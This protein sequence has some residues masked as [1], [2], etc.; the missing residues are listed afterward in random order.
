MTSCF[1]WFMLEFIGTTPTHRKIIKI[2]WGYRS[3]QFGTEIQ[4][5]RYCLCV[6]RQGTNEWS[7]PDEG[8][9]G[10]RGVGLPFR[11][12]TTDHLKKIYYLITMKASC[13][14]MRNVC[15]NCV[16]V[17]ISRENN[18]FRVSC[19]TSMYIRLLQAYF[20]LKTITIVCKCWFIFVIILTFW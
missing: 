14:R 20:F 15:L 9:E 18:N 10:L 17:R 1:Q 12:D 4:H 19:Q 5:F 13:L 6:S 2:W 11:I 3:R 7:L 16:P 8:S